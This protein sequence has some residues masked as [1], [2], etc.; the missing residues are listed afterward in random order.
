MSPSLHQVLPS[1]AARLGLPDQ[2]DHIDLPA[3]ERYIVVLIDGLGYHALERFGE[4][5]PF[6]AAQAGSPLIADFPTTTPVGLA[7]LGTGVP[8]G[9]HGIVGASF[10]LP[11]IDAVLSP[12][13]WPQDV[14]PHLVQPES[15]MFERLARSGVPSV[16]IGSGQYA[17]SGLTRAV[18]RGAQYVAAESSMEI[19]QHVQQHDAPCTYIYWSALD[20]VG[21]A[22]GIASP[23]WHAAL[24]DVDALVRGIHAACPKAAILVTADH[25]MVNIDQR[26]ALDADPNLGVNVKAIAGEPRMRHVY[27]QDPTDTRTIDVWQTVL[28]PYADVLDK[29]TAITTFDW[30][31]DVAVERMGDLMCLAKPGWLLSSQTDARVSRLPGQHGGLTDDERLIPGIVLGP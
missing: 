19:L 9:E 15:T 5:A 2:H 30:T 31:S 29:S 22:H 24:R 13:H 20:R 16:S 3:T 27:L 10:W 26:F 18:L 28:S 1:V 7:A 21:H 14:S 25:G 8:T 11:E 4:E 23:Q 12:L 17:I 6:L